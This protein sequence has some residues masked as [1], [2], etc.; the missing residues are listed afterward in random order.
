MP[1]AAWRS[2]SGD[3]TRSGMDTNVSVD[4]LDPVLWKAE[5]MGGSGRSEPLA[6]VFRVGDQG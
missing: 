4:D 2:A 6:R 1:R 5:R 3:G